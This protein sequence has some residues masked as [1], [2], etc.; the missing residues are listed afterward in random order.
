MR[1]IGRIGDG[2]RLYVKKRVRGIARMKPGDFFVGVIDFFSILLP[3]SLLAGTF[4]VMLPLP[5]PLEPLLASDTAK[6]VAFALA[7][8]AL[9]HFI[10]LISALLDG[11]YD[12]YR[13]RR[14]PRSDDEEQPFKQANA[15]RYAQFPIGKSDQGLPMNT[16]KWAKSVLMIRAPAAL[17]EVNRYEANSKFFRSMAVVLPIGGVAGHGIGF[18][19]VLPASLVLTFVSFLIYAQQRF[20]STEW[21]YIHVLVLDRLGELEGGRT[22]PRNQA[23]AG[24]DED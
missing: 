1:P 22:T 11:L 16:F 21:A 2:I 9:G 10:F 24:D 23:T 6:W 17:A 7:A 12:L 8:Y 15:L 5:A 20:K 14:W 19:Q 4:A 13:P 3:G 18:A